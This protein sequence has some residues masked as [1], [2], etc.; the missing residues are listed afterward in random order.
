MRIQNLGLAI[1]AAFAIAACGPQGQP[2]APTEHT[3]RAVVLIAYDVGYKTARADH[4]NRLDACARNHDDMNERA[5]CATAE[6]TR[7][8]VVSREF[9]EF[10]KI[11]KRAGDAAREGREGDRM[12]AAFE[13]HG[14]YCALRS[15]LKDKAKLPQPALFPCLPL[16]DHWQN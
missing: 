2:K 3:A 7:W 13:L 9:L 4:L 6:N 5:T 15:A 10:A 16:S 12:A 14:A 11:A 1:G 8:G